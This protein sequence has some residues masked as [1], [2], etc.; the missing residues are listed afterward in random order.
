MGV[1]GFMLFL[2]SMFPTMHVDRGV[3]VW[4]I[5]WQNKIGQLM[6]KKVRLM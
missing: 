5:F 4:E 6:F 3:G 1:V 2:D